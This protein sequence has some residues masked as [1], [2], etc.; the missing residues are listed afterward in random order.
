MRMRTTLGIGI[1]SC[2]CAVSALW[3][4]E[5][6]AQ[7]KAIYSKLRDRRCSSMTIDV[8]QCPDARELRS[9]VDGLL[10]A[11]LQERD[12][13]LRT[14]KK[15]TP[16]VIADEKLRASIEK[17][18]GK[19]APNAPAISSDHAVFNF[20]AAR[21]SAGKLIHNFT[22]TNK[23][24]SPLEIRNIRV[25]CTCSSVMLKAGTRQSPAFGTAGADKDW[26]EILAPGESARL[27]FTLDVGD[28]SIRPGPVTRNVHITSNDP[29]YP[30][31]TLRVQANVEL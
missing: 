14:A 1:V 21:K 27:E 20:G 23:G 12:I 5:I 6:P 30:E 4:E 26:K 15:F 11:G 19:D 31:F 13:L 7:K 29:V 8:C 9:Y 22:I 25:T 28:S 18:L 24:K 2:L 17:Q 3:A 10:D 16:V